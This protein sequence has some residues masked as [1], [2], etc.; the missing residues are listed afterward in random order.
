LG[1]PIHQSP[2]TESR[3]PL[4]SEQ[5]SMPITASSRGVSPKV[6][7]RLS[8]RVYD[9]E[10]NPLLSLEQ[11]FL[12]RLLPPLTR[13][14]VV[15]L[16]CGTGR[17]L[18]KLALR[19]PH[20]VVGVDLSPEM[21]GHAKRKV[22]DAAKLVVGDCANLPLPRSCAD[23]ILCTFLASYL[24]DIAKLAEQV[25]RILRPGGSIFV[26]DLHPATVSE[27]GWRRGF[28]V[29]GS[30]VDITTYSTPIGQIVSSF[31]A[32]G[33]HTDAV[34]E[35]QFGEPEFQTLKRAGQV[36]AFRAASCHPA[37]YILQ[38]RLR[39]RSSRRG[40]TF[41][42]RR[43]KRLT[44]A[45]AAIGAQE[46]TLA[47]I[48]IEE[49]RIGFLGRD[50]MA[51]PTHARE[52]KR[53]VD[54]S[55]FLLLPGLI[56]AHDHLE[57]ALFPRLGKGGYN[58]FVE[59]ADDIYRPG[60]STIS[61]HR[62]VPKNTR[63]WW[64][65]IRNLLS[66]VTTV[67]HHN[68]YVEE[69][70]SNGFAVRVL[71]DFAWAHSLPMEH[72]FAR[73]RRN[74]QPDQPFIIHLAEGIDLQSADEIFHLVREQALDD[75]TVLVHGLGLDARGMS[76]LRSLGAGLVWCP[77]SNVF[78]FGRT[79]SRETI[80]ALPSV[81][82]GSDSPLTAHGDLLD[83]VRFARETVGMP[84]EALYSLVTT[85]AAQ[86]LRLKNG[87]GTL[88]I[89]AFADLIGVRDTGL[90]PADT[91]GAMSCHD[92]ELVIIGGQVQLASSDVLARLPRSVTTGLR[93]LQI[94]GQ[95]RWLRAP[96]NRL[97]S[98]TQRH[99]TGEIKLGERRVCNGSTK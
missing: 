48:C 60:S 86:V 45:R 93:P 62:A 71:R 70:F 32:V 41:P 13:L 64:G 96:V 63:L 9:A 50:D 8:S 12:E 80:H 97:F 78:L 87:E 30:F 23:L 43:L 98:E 58:N 33:I 91:L 36:E 25:R 26:T 75:R 92:I 82:L 1:A 72:D 46:S 77:T 15:D 7:Y 74:A 40:T 38:L 59:W 81:A 44:G 20:S 57:F 90:S 69:L 94:D 27:L 6:G 10:P 29:D 24:Q 88:R 84:S 31:E 89:G 28:H 67:C 49:G 99:L 4:G 21:L 52:G 66:G 17:W 39:T 85:S 18:E 47:N 19:S 61:E 34:L 3:E 76:L 37:I 51:S 5:N 65:G 54:L 22:G 35:P 56:N 83:E 2:Q 14:D 95:V 53:S 73:K 42:A 55:G 79:H 16:G 11:R 68:P